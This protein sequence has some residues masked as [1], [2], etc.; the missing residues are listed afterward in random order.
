MIAYILAGLVGLSLGLL[1]GGGSILT[2]PILVYALNMDPKLSIALSL[3]IVG[4]TTLFGVYEH[5]RHKN[6]KFKLAFLFG[7][8]AIPGTFL[9]SYLSQFISGNTQ[10]IIFAI[11]MMTAA[12]FMFKG[13]KEVTNENQNFNYPLIIISGLFVG[14]MTGLIGVGGGFLIVPALMFF[15]KTQMR[16]AVGT[17]LLI[18]SIN[19]FFG[20]MSYIQLITIPWLFLIKFTVSSILG[21]LIGARLAN[22]VPQEKLKKIFAI[23]LVV[24]GI[25][26]LY[27]NTL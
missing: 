12:I 22:K 20:F 19:S 26:I 21:I 14:V 17:S 24:M 27:K 7:G 10:L 3:A 13:K 6:I 11:V 16:Q 18:I 2:V 1:G 5:Y 23:F 15:T 4:T 25:F 9:G 8:F